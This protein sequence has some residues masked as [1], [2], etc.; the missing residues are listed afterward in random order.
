MINKNARFFILIIMSFV[1]IAC[2][3]NEAYYKYASIPHNEWS[4]D[5]KIC[6]VLDS[7][8][9]N[10]QLT[11]DI[12]IEITHNVNYE[13]ENLW[14][15][16]D[17]KLN[18]TV[19]VRDTLECLLADNNGKWKGRGNGPTRQF[20]ILYKSNYRLDTNKRNQVYI[21]QAMQEPILKGIERIGLKIY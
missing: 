3:Q 15:Y 17:Q 1:L 5:E 8:K 11:Y 2:N 14:L 21:H 7:V 12:S 6:F 18:D 19:S 10:S 13:Y 4:K 16:I 9:F 20:S